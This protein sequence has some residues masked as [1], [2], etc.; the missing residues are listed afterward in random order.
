M[1]SA[2]WMKRS[3]VLLLGGAWALLAG[4]QRPAQART[5]V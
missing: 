2:F 1:S 3:L 5:L 4:L